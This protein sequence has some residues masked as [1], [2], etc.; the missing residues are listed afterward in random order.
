MENVLTCA[1]KPAGLVHTSVNGSANTSS[2]QE[3]VERHV[4]AHV[5]MY[6]AQN[7][8]PVAIL[9]LASVVRSVP[10]KM[11][12]HYAENAIKEDGINWS[13]ELRKALVPNS[14]SWKTVDTCL[15]YVGSIAG[16]TWNQRE[17]M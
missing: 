6:L 3:I 10:L 16:W 17:I 11:G 4:T 1:T 8:Y 12:G 5:V 15:R 2:V 9:V 7:V 14:F 13:L